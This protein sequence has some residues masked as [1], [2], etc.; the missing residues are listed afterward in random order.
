MVDLKDVR[1]DFPPNS[2][3]SVLLGLVLNCGLDSVMSTLGEIA[4]QQSFTADAIESDPK[5]EK[6]IKRYISLK[7]E[8]YNQNCSELYLACEVEYNDGSFG[9]IV[10]T[11]PTMLAVDRATCPC[12]HS[13]NVFTAV[14]CVACGAHTSPRQ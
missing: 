5:K 13:K 7:V 1:V 4:A 2:A 8:G 9:F 11:R 14:I 10:E 12:C 6:F 3:Y